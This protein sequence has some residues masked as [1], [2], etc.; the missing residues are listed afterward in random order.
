MVLT[1]TAGPGSGKTVFLRQLQSLQG[2]RTVYIDVAAFSAD[3]AILVRHL[4]RVFLQLW[5]ELGGYLQHNLEEQFHF[6]NA[7]ER[8]ETLVDELL[9][10]GNNPAAIA[11]DGCEILANR[12]LWMELVA[13]FLNRLPSFV[14]LT[15]SSRIPLQ[16]T[17]L[18][19]L[20]LQGRLLELGPDDLFFDEEEV[21]VFFSS[22]FP[23]INSQDAALV[24]EKVGGW[25]AGITLLGLEM[26]KRGTSILDTASSAC[27]HE[28][29]HCAVFAGLPSDARQILCALAL[30]QPFDD[31]VI[32]A[33]F[34]QNQ[35]FEV[36]SRC[37]FFF[38]AP[39]EKDAERAFAQL[40]AD[41]FQAQ[42]PI[43]LGRDGVRKLHRRASDFFRK[44][45]ANS[46]AL[47]HLIA[48]EAWREAVDLILATC[49]QWIEDEDYSQLP[50][51]VEQLPPEAIKRSPRLYMLLGQAHMYLGNLDAAGQAVRQAHLSARQGSKAWLESGCLLCEIMLLQGNKE[52]EIELASGLINRSR[53]ISPFRV[54]AM[55]FKA[56]GLNLMCRFQESDRLWRKVTTIARSR[57]VPLNKPTRCY[58]MAPK[59]VFHNLERGEFE[60]SGRIL[61][62]AIAVFRMQD[63]MKRLGWM[64]LFKG[65][66]KLEIHQYD[67]A[68]V[69]M[70]E[71]EAVSS[72]TNRSVHATCIAFLA[73]LLAI[74][75]Q[76]EEARQWLERAEPL[77]SRDLSMWAPII[78][79]LARA[80][81][82]ET[83][84][85]TEADLQLA[86]NLANQRQMLLP[87]TLTAYM[88][89]GL[90]ARMRST[91]MARMFCRQAA[92]KCRRWNVAHREARLLLYLS[93]LQQSSHPE[94]ADEDFRRAMRLISEREHG[95]VLTGDRDLDG[96]SLVLRAVELDIGT[97]FFLQLASYWGKQAF[98]ALTALFDQAR[99]EL[100]IKIITFWV[101]HGYRPA[102]GRIDQTIKK[103]RGKN[104]KDRLQ[105]L[106][107]KLQECP[108]DPLHIHL[109]GRFSVTRGEEEIP[110]TAWKRHRARDIF[111]Y[112]CLH[113]NTLF[114]REQL[115]DLFWP[116]VS[117]EKA[118]AQLWSAIS[119]IR[120]ALEPELPARAKSTYLSCTSQTYALD[121]P[122][123]S[124]IDTVIFS[125]KI[126]EGR[127]FIQ[128]DDTARALLS[129]EG[130]VQLYSD[131]L[132][133][134]DR[135]AA[136][137]EEEREHY[138]QLLTD[139]LR[140]MASIYMEQRDF[141]ATIRAYRKIIS[142]DNWDE[143][144]YL[145]LMRC[146]VLQ[147]RELKAVEVYQQCKKVLNRELGIAPAR[148]VTG[149]C[150]APFAQTLLVLA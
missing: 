98:E 32:T 146:Y 139:T 80:R 30:V 83:S 141:D 130:A 128:R 55:M 135:Y 22:R 39:A 102:L 66:C 36:I 23:A 8:F 111:K 79:C 71:A 122:E 86:W 106:R 38:T 17:A 20:R 35:V 91:E 53:M 125:T 16:F 25:P 62:E 144:S 68:L 101:R 69:W 29:M 121:L 134:G 61:D 43:V 19:K 40:Y 149:I 59:A 89:H 13:L 15:L 2:N 93:L 47:V 113:P 82:A 136:W 31:Q 114:T 75:D 5:P 56:I 138:S 26:E 145:A 140:S 48:L 99:L 105:R 42:A 58:I 54:R 1:L 21:C 11:F 124:S 44:K 117:P 24:H 132:L 49:Q 72:R 129:F 45:G 87:L 41:F 12:P 74:L 57:F 27:L 90:P 88:A 7:L 73:L 77:A 46:R 115:A 137:C 110:E 133:P 3:S 67:E 64:L 109:F 127:H 4:E 78:C 95:F 131:G 103:T 108:P 148:G 14:S 119:T 60:E 9:L 70:R 52:E 107:R 85:D 51:W 104:T 81:I 116:E 150:P 6:S 84:A 34:D 37:A 118:K 123:G 33:L 142:L 50:Y 10:A 126:Q 92:D 147:G 76:R 96:L 143:D 18:P 120:T 65:I 100:K 63:P 94:Q 112:L 28:Y 97:D